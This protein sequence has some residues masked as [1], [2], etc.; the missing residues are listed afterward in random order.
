M[1]TLVSVLITVWVLKLWRADLGIP[2]KYSDDGLLTSSAVKG[3]IDNGWLFHNSYLG[4]P[5][6]QSL[7]DYPSAD[8][9]HVLAIKFLTLFSGNWALVMNLFFLATFPLTTLTS[10]FVLRRMEISYPEAL[11]GSL[12]F[13]FIP[14]HLLHGEQHLFLAALYIVP[15]SCLAILRICSDR[16]PLI[17]S[18]AGRERYDFRSLRTLG[19]IIVALLTASAGIYYAV[20]AC[21]LLVVSGIYVAFD[22]KSLKR[23]VTAGILAAIIFFGLIVNLSPSIIHIYRD[24][25]NQAVAV[26]DPVDAEL[27]GTTI[28]QL[29]LPVTGHRI[30]FLADLKQKYLDGAA[31]VHE[32][33]TFANENDWTPLGLIGSA[34]FLFLLGWLVFARGRYDGRDPAFY[35]LLDTLSVLNISALLLAVIGGFGLLIAML[36]SPEIRAYN[37]IGVYISFFAIL[38]VVLV[39][40]RLRRKYIRTHV[41]QRLF[42]V[43]LLLLLAGGIFDQTDKSMVPDYNEIR[44]AYASDAAFVNKIEAVM[45][46]QA[47]VFQLPY[48]P[49]PENPTI[50]NMPDYHHL[51]AYLHSHDIRWSYGAMKGRNGDLWLR[52]VANQPPPEFVKEIVENGFRGV[53]INRN[54]YAPGVAVELETAMEDILKEKPVV[55]DDGSLLFFDL[56]GYARGLEQEQGASSPS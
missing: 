37:R 56:T 41:G 53:Y 13:T 35:P 18:E 48:A 9:L 40:G 31:L 14:Y 7:L 15:L 34:G 44:K 38:T 52:K 10:L 3:I 8:N 26:R 50:A 27:L 11:L 22:R 29:V 17:R 54:G 23:L 45:P 25:K 32:S 36:F 43:V 49:F 33:H 4:A 21:F 47:M 1:A 19:F 28:T 42:F 24:G 46:A 12:L 55:N 39:L 16:P 30:G 5:F 51:T 20:F 2:F 6:G